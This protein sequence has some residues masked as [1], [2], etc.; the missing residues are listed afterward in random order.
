MARG[1]DIALPGNCC[2]LLLSCVAGSRAAHGSVV[3][4]RGESANEAKR[5]T[6]R[7]VDAG[8]GAGCLLGV[9]IGPSLFLVFNYSLG[10]GRWNFVV[11]VGLSVIVTNFFAG[12]RNAAKSTPRCSDSR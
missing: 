5:G 11:V 12:A 6:F 8:G 9:V 7:D 1:R 2:L 10:F 3:R 4:V